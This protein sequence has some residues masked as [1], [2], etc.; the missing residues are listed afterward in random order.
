MRK[1]ISIRSFLVLLIIAVTII[2]FIFFRINDEY[3]PGKGWKLVWSDEFNSETIDK[4]NWTHDLGYGPNDDGWGLSGM[5]EYT[6]DPKNAYI[7]NGKLVLQAFYLGGEFEARNY[8]SAKLTT[9]KKQSFKYGKIA[10]RIKM[11]YG[12]GIFPAFWMLGTD[13]EETGWPKCGEIDIVEMFGG[14][15]G[16]DDT[17][18]GT[19]H[20]FDDNE[21]GHTHF[22]SKTTL[23]ENL[24][25]LFHVY[26][27]EWDENVVVWKLDGK[28]YHRES[29]AVATHPERSELHNESFL[30][31]NLAIGAWVE[32][33]GY[34]NETTE[35]PQ[36]IEFDWV[37][38]YKKR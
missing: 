21:Q 22:G 35:F 6:S 28:E 37:R 15:R 31:L 2:F 3:N 7:E 32:G 17:A 36:K 30:L 9:Y 34:P 10:A 25:E 16:K 8:T 4:S 20:Y 29:I 13:I 18:L 23:D 11:P 12:K 1:N 5:Q 33:V 26:T 24:S 27:I 14:G 38:V 19:V